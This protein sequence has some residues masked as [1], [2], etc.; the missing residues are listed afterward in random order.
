MTDTVR[1]TG[2]FGYTA[3]IKAPGTWK[4]GGL[5]LT[6]SDTGGQT[7]RE[8]M[9][10]ICK[11][12][13]RI[14]LPAKP[15]L[16]TAV[17]DIVNTRGDEPAVMA[18]MLLALVWTPT[19]GTDMLPTNLFTLGAYKP[20]DV[21]PINAARA[22][23]SPPLPPLEQIDDNNVTSVAAQAIRT[24]GGFCN[25]RQ[26]AYVPAISTNVIPKFA[27]LYGPL[28]T[29]LRASEHWSRSHHPQGG[30]YNYIEFVTDDAQTLVCQGAPTWSIHKK[31]GK[32]YANVFD[33]TGV[34]TKRGIAIEASALSNLHR[35]DRE[36][37]NRDQDKNAA[38]YDQIYRG[39]AVMSALIAD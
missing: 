15:T 36:S 24:M 9:K 17:S 18:F 35:G 21:G 6:C 14:P 1:T 11:T 4:F 32:A 34:W 27:I 20:Q 31:V 33:P 12:A 8:L 13:S 26:G 28:I 25:C 38:S 39:N 23:L 10:D 30:Q 5:T 2:G 37:L 3:R 7:W 16:F 19:D 22:L 29:I